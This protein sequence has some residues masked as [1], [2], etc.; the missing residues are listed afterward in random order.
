MSDED[1]GATSSVEPAAEGV[2]AEGA[3][4]FLRTRTTAASTSW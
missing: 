2:M 4:I 3:G 1:D